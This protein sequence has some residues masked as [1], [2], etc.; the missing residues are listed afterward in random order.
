[1]LPFEAQALFTRLS[2][3][4]DDNRAVAKLLYSPEEI[5]EMQN[6]KN[7]YRLMIPMK[8]T[9]NYSN[10]ATIGEKLLKK[11]AGN[12]GALLGFAAHGPMGA[13]IGFG[14]EK[15]AKA[16]KEASAARNTQRL[17]FGKQPKSAGS[18]SV[19]PALVLPAAVAGGRR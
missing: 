4:L 14:S 10:S 3:F 1:M 17:F 15:I 13:L 2:R 5:K 9:V 18:Y 16:A 7:A 6:L 19:A 12:V 11:S 8:G